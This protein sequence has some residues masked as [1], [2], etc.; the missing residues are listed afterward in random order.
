M[1]TRAMQVGLLVSREAT[2]VRAS[3]T[4]RILAQPQWATPFTLGYIAGPNNRRNM[5]TSTGGKPTYYA[6]S[7]AEATVANRALREKEQ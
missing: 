4:L 6:V 1:I 5:F 2:K 3:V 7:V